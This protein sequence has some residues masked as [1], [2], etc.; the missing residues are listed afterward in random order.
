M[1]RQFPEI[2]RE[3]DA[4]AVTEDLTAIL[5]EVVQAVTTTRKVGGVTLAL[6]IRP[7]GENSVFVTHD[8]KSKIPEPPK[9]DT[10]FFTTADGSMRR[11]DPSQQDLPLRRVEAPADADEPREAQG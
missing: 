4:G 2:L 6:K 3:L 11:S 1:A 8:I 7:N 5:A 9:S 10:L